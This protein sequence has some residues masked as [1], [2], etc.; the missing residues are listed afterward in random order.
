MTVSF[1][2]FLHIICLRKLRQ[3]SERFLV[4][5]SQATNDLTYLTYPIFVL[6]NHG[7]TGADVFCF[8]KRKSKLKGHAA[9]DQERK[10][11]LPKSSPP[12]SSPS[13]SISSLNKLQAEPAINHPGTIMLTA[14]ATRGFR[15]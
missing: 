1:I 12:K 11:P 3:Y 2:C 10:P 5:L 14:Q 9:A 4:Y 15:G 13:G 7:I 8:Q 6:S